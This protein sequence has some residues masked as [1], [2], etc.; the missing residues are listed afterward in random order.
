MSV[1]FLLLISFK[2]RIFVNFGVILS[3]NYGVI[4]SVVITGSRLKQM[5]KIVLHNSV[6]NGQDWWKKFID[7]TIEV[8][9]FGWAVAIFY[10]T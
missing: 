9:V 3:F 1:F 7:L 5:E 4:I 6:Y 10:D 2:K 8:V